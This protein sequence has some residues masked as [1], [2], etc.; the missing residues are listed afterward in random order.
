MT[1]HWYPF[2]STRPNSNRPSFRR[3]KPYSVLRLREANV[4]S[5]PE[6]VPNA[7]AS[8]HVF[9]KYRKNDEVLPPE[10]QYTTKDSLSV[11]KY[12]LDEGGK[13]VLTG[14]SGTNQN[15]FGQ[16][17]NRILKSVFLQGKDV[18][19][20]GTAVDDPTIDTWVQLG[21]QL[22]TKTRWLDKYEEFAVQ[23]GETFLSVDA[24]QSNTSIPV[25]ER[26]TFVCGFTHTLVT[27]TVF[28]PDRVNGGFLP[29]GT[30]HQFSSR[31]WDDAYEANED[32]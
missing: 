8:M 18:Q 6:F 32:I 12:A 15:A 22:P 17:T 26:S 5:F 7:R 16:G 9:S 28:V 1:V 14:L 3:R 2:H 13:L 20:D 27:D 11:V 24:Y 23:I 21:E 31:V 29:E 30:W 25:P 19:T 4:Y 10:L